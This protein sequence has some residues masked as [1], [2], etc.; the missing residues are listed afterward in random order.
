MKAEERAISNILTEQ[1]CYEIP[2]YQRPYS[3]EQENTQQL[4]EDVWEAYGAND[5]EYFIGSLITIEKERDRRYE[6]VDG[7]QRL[8]TLN[9]IFARLRDHIADEAAKAELG[10]RILPRNVLTGE[11]E[12]PR[13]L[14]R[15]KD[16][17][18]FRKYVVDAQ[19]LAKKDREDLEAPQRHLAE[20]LETVDKFCENKSQQ[21]LRLFANYL[22]SKVYVVFVT[23]Y[24]WQ[25]AYRLFNVLNARGMSLSNADLIKNILFSQL[26]PQAS[27]SEEL[28]ERWLELEEEVGIERLDAFFGHHR[29]A[30]TAIKAQKTL[31]EEIEP[32]IRE[33]KGGPFAFLEHVI[34]SAQNYMRIGGDDFE[35]PSTL[36]SLRGLRRVAYDEWI[37]P[38]LAYLNQ[39]VP[40]LPEQEFVGLLE[41]I[42]IQ[43]WVR[44]LGRTARLTAYHQLISAIKDGKRADDVRQIFRKNAKNTEFLE[45]L[46]GELYG[47]PFDAAVLLRLEEAT[48]DESVSKTYSGSVT[49]EHVLS[50][51]LKDDY[52]KSRFSDEQHK[53]WLHRLGNLALLSGPKNYKAQYY[54]F[55]RKKKIY[56]DRNKKV[57]FDIT[58]EVCDQPEWT[59]EIIKRRH[60][61]LLKLAEQVWTIE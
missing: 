8:T 32:L 5:N 20:N 22:L 24:S 56:S 34:V 35:D 58:K 55:E 33:T 15:K 44:R 23:T 28:E 10:K 45:L 16:Q 19:P 26:G 27:R 14:L 21:V 7:Q 11:A 54:D 39:P 48:Q 36:R 53:I 31:H 40:G 52:W 43:S 37:P 25:S 13:L 18:F 9:L 38:L 60:E 3:W 59:V 17:A 6:V 2:P 51:A 46:G 42:T 47:K 61:R 4:L 41:K 57:S 50:Q 30:L 1:I 49:I 12:T 29:T